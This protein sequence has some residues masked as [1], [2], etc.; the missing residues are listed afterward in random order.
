M[1]NYTIKDKEQ[2]F[3]K[4]LKETAD[5]FKASIEYDDTTKLN[6]ITCDVMQLID[7]F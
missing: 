3:F 2:E 4:Y 7:K 1:E 5:Q 6:Q